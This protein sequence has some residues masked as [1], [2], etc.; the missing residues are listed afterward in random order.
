[1][2]VCTWGTIGYEYGGVVGKPISGYLFVLR[3]DRK[4]SETRR[5]IFANLISYSINHPLIYYIWMDLT[6]NI[7]F[8]L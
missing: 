1:M 6:I 3:H 2:S 4:G 8:F 7:I 5:N